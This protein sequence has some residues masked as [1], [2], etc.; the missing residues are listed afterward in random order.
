MMVELS[1]KRH[2]LEEEESK[3]R[4][5]KLTLHKFYRIEMAP[6]LHMLNRLVGWRKDKQETRKSHLHFLKTP[7]IPLNR[8]TP[9][10]L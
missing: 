3:L 2:I 8:N 9:R 5:D 10:T 6:V 4:Y 1:H 7:F